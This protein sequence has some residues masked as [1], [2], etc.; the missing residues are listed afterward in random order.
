MNL[1]TYIS[2]LFAHIASNI[3]KIILKSIWPFTFDVLLSSEFP[4]TLHQV[5]E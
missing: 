5:Y 3:F 1:L 2:D 4:H